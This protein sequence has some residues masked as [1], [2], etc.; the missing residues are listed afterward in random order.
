MTGSAALQVINALIYTSS[1]HLILPVYSIPLL[2]QSQ[3]YGGVDLSH[4]YFHEKGKK[5]TGFVSGHT[6]ESANV[7]AW[8][9]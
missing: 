5:C 8:D 1:I 3:H 9:F 2:P 6:C 7:D 4:F